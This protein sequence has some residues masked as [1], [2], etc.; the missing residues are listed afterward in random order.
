MSV[1]YHTSPT[2]GLAGAEVCAYLRKPP[3][4][5]LPVIATSPPMVAEPTTPK[6]AKLANPPLVISSPP[7]LAYVPCDTMLPFVAICP[8]VAVMPPAE[9]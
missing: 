7:I 2:T 9:K 8:A 5:I 4:V 6:L 3:A 1:L